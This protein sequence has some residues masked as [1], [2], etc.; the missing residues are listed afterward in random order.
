MPL[1]AVRIW[2]NRSEACMRSRSGKSG[3]CSHH[4]A[5]APSAGWTTF[6]SRSRNDEQWDVDLFRD[7]DGPLREMCV[8]DFDEG[9]WPAR[10]VKDDD[11]GPAAFAARC[12]LQPLADDLMCAVEQIV[13]VRM[14]LLAL[15]RHELPRTHGR[16][17]RN[18]TRRWMQAP[19][20]ESTPDAAAQAPP[21]VA[22]AD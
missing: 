1:V 15:P 11:V 13:G 14:E 20:P 22:K 5:A 6:P 19:K 7:L 10:G 8:D 3:T 18:V 16:P 4:G 2:V 12:R 9:E 17:G 21:E